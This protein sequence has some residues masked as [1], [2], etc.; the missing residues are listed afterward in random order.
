MRQS[1]AALIT[2]GLS[3]FGRRRRPASFRRKMPVISISSTSPSN[4]SF[5]EIG[6]PDHLA[7]DRPERR[8]QTWT[9][10]SDPSLVLACRMI[11]EHKHAWLG[12]PVT[13]RRGTVAC[14]TSRRDR[15]LLSHDSAVCARRL[16]RQRSDF[17]SMPQVPA[18]AASG[19]AS[20][21]SGHR[22]DIH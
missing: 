8:T 12:S 20:T 6:P 1:R 18:R 11:R 16:Q 14:D 3:R 10:V 17:R 7:R 5:S 22:Q 9:L 4:G 13:P 21:K 19:Q 2:F 15:H